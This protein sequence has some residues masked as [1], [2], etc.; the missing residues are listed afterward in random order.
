MLLIIL[1]RNQPSC[2]LSYF[3]WR[4]TCCPVE[5]SLLYEESHTIWLFLGNITSMC[6][7]LFVGMFVCLDLMPHRTYLLFIFYLWLREALC[8][9]IV[10]KLLLQTVD[11][12]LAWVTI[13]VAMLCLRRYLETSGKLVEHSFPWFTPSVC[14]HTTTHSCPIKDVW[15]I[16]RPQ[17]DSSDWF[18][19]SIV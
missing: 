6:F 7:C 3:W 12:T 17:E 10:F 5:D 14:L 13:I 18:Q 2:S 1:E 4:G 15:Y 16:N 9:Q 8:Y 19:R 11:W